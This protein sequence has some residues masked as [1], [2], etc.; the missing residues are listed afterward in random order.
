MTRYVYLFQF[1]KRSSDPDSATD[2]SVVKYF[3]FYKRSSKIHEKIHHARG[4]RAFNSIRDLRL[5]H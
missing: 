1:Y 4:N 5:A 2:P 3:Q